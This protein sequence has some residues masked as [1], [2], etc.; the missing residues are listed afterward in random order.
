MSVFVQIYRDAENGELVLRNVDETGALIT[1]LPSITLKLQDL[2]F[3]EELLAKL[4]R[5]HYTDANDSSK[6]RCYGLFT[7]PESDA[8]DD[9]HSSSAEDLYLGGGGGGGLIQCTITTLYGASGNAEYFEATPTAGGAAIKV[10]KSIPARGGATDNTKTVS[11]EAQVMLPAFTMGDTVDVGTID[12]TGVTVSGVELTHI[13]VST[14]R[15]WCHP[16]S[17][18]TISGTIVLTP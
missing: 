17:T 15:G 1:D 11:G 10:A 2:E 8:A 5:V 4:R 12:H 6:K 18:A 7:K 3:A 13:E 14:E 9:G 16:V